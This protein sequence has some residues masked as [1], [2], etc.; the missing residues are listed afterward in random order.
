MVIFNCNPLKML[1][2][3]F[4]TS[5]FTL[6]EVFSQLATCQL[7]PGPFE[8]H[9]YTRGRQT[10]HRNKPR[11]KQIKQEWTVK[12]PSIVL[13]YRWTYRLVVENESA[14]CV[15]PSQLLSNPVTYFFSC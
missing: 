15:C 1:P 11:G 6:L 3:R 5:I 14:R 8:E 13:A 10:G 2:T 12:W 4:L 9:L 7:A